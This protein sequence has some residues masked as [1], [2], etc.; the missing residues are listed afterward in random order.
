MDEVIFEEF[1]GTGNSE[2]VL[3]RKLA[4]KRTFPAIDIG[5]SGTRKEELLVDK[6][7]LSKMWVLRRI[8]L[9]MGV[10]DSVEFLVEKLK[11]AKTNNDFFEAMNQ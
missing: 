2:I 11:H 1:K 8:L 9:P 6:G 5:K 10:T 4:D 3:D 7:T